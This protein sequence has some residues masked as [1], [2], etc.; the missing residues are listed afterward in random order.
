MFQDLYNTTDNTNTTTE[1]KINIINTNVNEKLLK[2]R[3]I[4]LEKVNETLSI[5]L[6]VPFKGTRIPTVVNNGDHLT[7]KTLFA[8]TN[9]PSYYTINNNDNSNNN[10]H[11]NNTT[12]DNITNNAT[13]NITNNNSIINN[14]QTNLVKDIEKDIDKD[15]DINIMANSNMG[16]VELDRD[17]DKCKD[18]ASGV[19]RDKNSIS[20]LSNPINPATQIKHKRSYKRKEVKH[21]SSITSQSLDPTSTD[22]TTNGFLRKTTRKGSKNSRFISFDSSINGSNYYSKYISTQVVM[23][24]NNDGDFS[25]GGI[26][27]SN[28]TNN[29][30]NYNENEIFS[31]ATVD[32]Y[33]EIEQQNEIMQRYLSLYLSI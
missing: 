23:P 16:S 20:N 27:N 26:D 12:T 28:N 30:T 7:R 29:N 1:S 13:N 21:P 19:D 4:L 6:Q 11:H 22:A 25:M 8:V 17:R 2:D 32:Y 14:N 18:V 5:L 24:T 10:K 9:Q 31:Q 3:H 33:N 15:I